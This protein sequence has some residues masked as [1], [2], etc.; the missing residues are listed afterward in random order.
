M[1][2]E[3]LFALLDTV[4][5]ATL[6]HVKKMEENYANQV[7]Q[8][9]AGFRNNL[10]W[11]LGH[12]AAV[13]DR[14]THAS[15]G[16]DV[17]LPEAFHASFARGTSPDDWNDETP[18]FEEIVKVLREQPATLKEKFAGQ[19]DNPLPNPFKVAGHDFQTG[20]EVLAFALFHEGIHQGTMIGIMKNL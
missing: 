17:T 10:R 19:L 5:G 6:H 4:R 14:L 2:E 12:V 16:Q 9:P 15:V 20:A 13:L 8:I 18:S 11:N 3:R 1:K 7:D